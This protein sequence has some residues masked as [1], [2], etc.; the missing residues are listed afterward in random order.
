MAKIVAAVGMNDNGPEA[1][2]VAFSLV[3]TVGHELCG[4][5][6]LEQQTRAHVLEAHT[7]EEI[8]NHV[9]LVTA[10]DWQL[11]KSMRPQLEGIGY[12]KVI[13]VQPGLTFGE[14]KEMLKD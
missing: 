13:I 1:Y 9:L 12:K 6:V 2:S 3:S 10:T 7:P 8:A 11:A 14:L 4:I 5:N